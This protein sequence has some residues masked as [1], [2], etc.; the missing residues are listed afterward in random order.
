MFHMSR[1]G[2]YLDFKPA[3]DFEP[4]VPPEEFLGKNVAEVLPATVAEDVLRYIEHALNTGEVQS[5]EYELPMEDAVHSYEAR[6]VALGKDDVLAIVRDVTDDQ[7]SWRRSRQSAQKPQSSRYRLT[8]RELS[9]LRLVTVGMTDKEIAR[10]LAISA[11][12]VRKHVGSVRVKM[13]AVS[14]T[15]ASVRAVR[16]GLIV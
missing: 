6:I 14:R 1:D 7:A 11:D 8:K 15:D 16:E 5:Y 9:V 4:F 3:K 10:R 12:T 2:R 13:N